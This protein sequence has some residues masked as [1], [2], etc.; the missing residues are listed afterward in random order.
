M[1]REEGTGTS[2]HKHKHP[3]GPVAQAASRAEQL[4]AVEEQGPGTCVSKQEE[5][6][7]CRGASPMKDPQPQA[8]SASLHRS[9]N[10]LGHHTFKKRYSYL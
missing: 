5:P 2:Q 4:V 1:A 6:R 9:S 3:P 7:L 8:H 10:K